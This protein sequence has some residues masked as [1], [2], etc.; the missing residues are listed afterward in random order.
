MANPEICSL[1]RL[2]TA[3]VNSLAGKIDL[4]GHIER[5]QQPAMRLNPSWRIMVDGNKV[6]SKSMKLNNIKVLHNETAIADNI[7]LLR[8]SQ[9]GFDGSRNK[10]PSGTR[11]VASITI[12]MSRCSDQLRVVRLESS[13]Q[14]FSIFLATA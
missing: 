8:F 13:S 2:H 5:N 12:L 7:H 4:L 6:M 11:L 3:M 9:N 14:K 10:N 1:N